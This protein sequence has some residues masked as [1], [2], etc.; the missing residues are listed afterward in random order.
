VGIRPQNIKHFHFLVKDQPVGK[1][2][3]Q[4]L[5]VLGDFMRTIILQKYFKFDMI[6]FTGYGVIAEKLRICHLGRIFPC[7]LQEKLYFGSKTDCTLFD[8]LDVLYHHAKFGEDRMPAVSAKIW[9]LYIF[10]LLLSCCE[11]G[12]L[13]I[14]AGIL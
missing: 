1:L 12:A 6:R 10:C 11:A 13:F 14:P 5:Q 8:G 2:L 9:C 7:I 4:F 3:D